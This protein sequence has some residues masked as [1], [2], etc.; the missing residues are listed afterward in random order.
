M[1]KEEFIKVLRKLVNL[2]GEQ[3]LFNAK[4]LQTLLDLIITIENGKE[5]EWRLVLKE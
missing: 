1:E 4:E 3:N 2:Y 5:D